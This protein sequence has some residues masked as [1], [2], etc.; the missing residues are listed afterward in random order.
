MFRKLD[1]LQ[2]TAEELSQD[3]KNEVM[4]Y[5]TLNRIQH[6]SLYLTG[7]VQHY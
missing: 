7:T 5:S 4:C 6:F 3:T 1:V 2:K